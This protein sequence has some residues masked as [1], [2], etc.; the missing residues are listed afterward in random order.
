MKKSRWLR[1][2]KKNA[3]LLQTLTKNELKVKYASSYLGI[4]WSLLEP[5]L[6]IGV[7]SL[8]F[9]LI[10]KVDFLS[11][12]L[13]FVCGLIPFRFLR[14]GVIETTRSLVEKGEIINKVKIPLLV[15]PLSKTLAR[16]IVFLIECS[17]FFILSLLFVKLTI[18]LLLFPLIALS[19]FLM[20]SGLG[21]Y[22]SVY[23]PRYRDLDYILNVVFEALLFLTPI[24]YRVEMIPREYR[25][26]YMLNPFARLIYAY[27][28]I[29]LYA[30]PYFVKTS[31]V[32]NCIFVF[33]A[34]VVI[35]IIG[36]KIFE[37]HKYEAVGAI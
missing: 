16:F 28:G 23:Y 11:W 34:S 17:I 36:I 12:V 14:S 1:W 10:L 21:L 31:I 5:L 18:M 35:F 8:V 15:I 7:Y 27:Q 22:F 4:F 25:N 24:V 3:F 37:K 9:P 6:M 2:L 20:V 29:M 26:V 33:I 32:E 30:S 13:F 19:E